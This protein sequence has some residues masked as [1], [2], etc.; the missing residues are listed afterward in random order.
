M[1]GKALTVLGAAGMLI[2]TSVAA[3]AVVVGTPGDEVLRGTD[4]HDRI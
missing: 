3:A 1:Q 2:A 4:Q